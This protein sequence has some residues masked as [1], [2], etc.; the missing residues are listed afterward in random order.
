MANLSYIKNFHFCSSTK[1]ELSYWLTSFEA[2]VEFIS[3][4]NLNLSQERKVTV[5]YSTVVLAQ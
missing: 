4:G 3:Q 5:H 2:A 1:D